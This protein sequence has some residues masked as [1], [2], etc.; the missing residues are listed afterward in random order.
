MNT[1]HNHSLRKYAPKV[2]KTAQENVLAMAL[3]DIPLLY[4]KPNLQG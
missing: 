2:N 4:R 1:H 3:T